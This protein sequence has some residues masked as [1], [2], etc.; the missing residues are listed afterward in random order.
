VQFSLLAMMYIAII[1][2][3]MSVCASN[4]YEGRALGLFSEEHA[5]DESS[6]K[7]YLKSHI[8][9]LLSFDLWY[10]FIGVFCITVAESKKIMGESNPVR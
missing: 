6:G 1:P 5:Y 8:R 7:S 10:I 3:A 2:I 9:H 4:T